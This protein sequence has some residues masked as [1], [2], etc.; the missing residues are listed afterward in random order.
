MSGR[1]R[2]S[3]QGADRRQQWLRSDQ[4]ARIRPWAYEEL[5]FRSGSDQRWRTALSS[6]ASDLA[7]ARAD[8]A[9]TEEELRE[10]VVR[11]AQLEALIQALTSPGGDD[12]ATRVDERRPELPAR[13]ASVDP[14]RSRASLERGYSLARCEGFRVESPAGEVGFV[15]GLRFVSRID[16]PD[17]LEVRGGRLGRRRLLIPVEDVEEISPAEERVVVRSRPGLHDEP[18]R[19]L[20]DR[21]RRALSVHAGS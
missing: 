8:L 15:E 10:E 7:A 19:G 4:S 21:L 1:K 14:E 18:L 2:S 3:P 5:L 13:F 20:A 12:Q 11:I 6:L 9:R 16:Q 17:L